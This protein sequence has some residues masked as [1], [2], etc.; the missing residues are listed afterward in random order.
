MFGLITALNGILAP[1]LKNIFNLRRDYHFRVY[2]RGGFVTTTPLTM[3]TALSMKYGL[4]FM[5]IAI[6]NFI[7]FQIG[8]KS[9]KTSLA[10]F[11]FIAAAM[12]G[13]AVFSNG[14]LATWALVSVG[15]FN[16]IMFPTI[17]SLGVKQLG[18]HTPVGSGALMM[19]C[20]GGGIVPVI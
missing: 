16:S 14:G 2:R 19:G 8:K 7:A 6:I 20:L 10:V 17:F 12:V 5:G 15:F 3:P 9:D 13:I 11:A 1:H 4:I 18:K